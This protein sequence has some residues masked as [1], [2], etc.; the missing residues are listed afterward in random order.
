MRRVVVPALFLTL[1]PLT[2]SHAG[3]NEGGILVI[4]GDPDLNVWP[5]AG[6]EAFEIPETCFEL[7][8]QAYPY[9]GSEVYSCLVL[10]AFPPGTEPEVSELSF[11]LGD[12][13]VSQGYLIGEPCLPGALELP[14]S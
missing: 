4:H 2:G 1:L 7:N 8:P 6:C 13:D 9:Q 14:T 11:G 10:M 12:Y 3:P 5:T